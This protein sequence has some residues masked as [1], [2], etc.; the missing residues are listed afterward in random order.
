MPG[1]EPGTSRLSMLSECA[2][3]LR[4]IPV[5]PSTHPHSIL[6]PEPSGRPLRTQLWQN[7]KNKKPWL[8]S[9]VIVTTLTLH[10]L[11]YFLIYF[12]YTISSIIDYEIVH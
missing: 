12:V 1:L 11:L 7:N 4:Y 3:H 5:D 6:G 2:Y 10:R 9:I 8:E